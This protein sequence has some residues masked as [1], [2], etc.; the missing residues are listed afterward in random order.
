MWTRLFRII[1]LATAIS[2]HAYITGY[3]E[4]SGQAGGRQTDSGR[5]RWRLRSPRRPHE[6]PRAS[7]KP[8]SWTRPTRVVRW[9][10]PLGARTTVRSRVRASACQTLVVKP[11]ASTGEQAAKSDRQISHAEDGAA[12][13]AVVAGRPVQGV[14]ARMDFSAPLPIKKGLSGGRDEKASLGTPPCQSPSQGRRTSR[15]APLLADTWALTTSRQKSQVRCSSPQT[16][17]PALNQYPLLRRK[18]HQ[19]ARLLG[20]QRRDRPTE[21]H[22][23]WRHFKRPSGKECCPPLGND[24][25]KSRYMFLG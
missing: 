8:T 4:A 19:G 12:Y 25:T 21:R 11:T 5:W 2:V 22:A 23:C 14:N 9:N 20:S 1:L 18:Q 17:V 15:W 16:R 6:P 7:A 3:I 10:L 24:V 13:A